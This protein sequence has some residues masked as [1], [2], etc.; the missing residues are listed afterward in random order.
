MKLGW[1]MPDVVKL[2]PVLEQLGYVDIDAVLKM[3]QFQQEYSDKS[4]TLCST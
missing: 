1:H 2:V 3:R 4:S